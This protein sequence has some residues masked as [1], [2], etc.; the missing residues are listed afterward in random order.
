M[1]A[2]LVYKS[3]E[4]NVHW[5]PEQ[6]LK[7]S[8]FPLK[9]AGLYAQIHWKSHGVRIGMSKNLR[10]RIYKGSRWIKGMHDGTESVEQLGRAKNN[11]FC[12]AAVRDGLFGFGHYLISC[13]IKLANESFRSE[14]EHFL[15]DWV[16]KHAI[17]KD[18]NFQQDYC[19]TLG[20]LTLAQVETRENI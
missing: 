5:I 4:L 6:S 12:E 8:Q 17:Y 15:F 14:V 18:F 3:V 1:N 16:A 11:P 13:D 2:I 19:N 20:G 9:S 10:S 7:H